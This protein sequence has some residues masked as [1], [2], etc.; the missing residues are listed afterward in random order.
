LDKNE[1]PKSKLPAFEVILSG[2]VFLVIAFFDAKMYIELAGKEWLNVAALT[3]AALVLDGSKIALWVKFLA[4]RRVI[5]LIVAICLAV[6]SMFGSAGA[7]LR[8]I[9]EQKGRTLEASGEYIRLTRDLE[10]ARE[11]QVANL[12]RKNSLISQ[13]KGIA[14]IEGIISEN[15]LRM[16]TMRARLAA[17]E[18]TK[19]VTSGT[20]QFDLLAKYLGIESEL[21]K[22]IFMLSVFS[23][24]EVAAFLLSYRVGSSGRKRFY[25]EGHILDRKGNSLCGTLRLVDSGKWKRAPER[26]ICYACLVQTIQS[27]E[28]S[29]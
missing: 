15:E 29:K 22:L 8:L 25:S 17:L 5:M 16:D 2:V 19:E 20:V 4:T 3:L 18:G 26:T 9:E 11:N 27:K 7:S 10:A 13:E 28:A 21:L 12:A 14:G 6:L 1:S 24:L 23:I